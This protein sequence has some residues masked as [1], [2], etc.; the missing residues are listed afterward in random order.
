[1][2][3]NRRQFLA[4]GLV[5]G[6]MAIC[7][8]LELIS[9]ETGYK[10]GTGIAKITD[11]AIGQVMQGMSDPS[12]KITGVETDLY[13]R[14]FVIANSFDYM[15]SRPVIIVVTD[16]WAGS[17]LIKAE[18]I[19]RLISQYALNYENLVISVTHTHS[20]SGG[21]TG[22]AVY[23]Y[24]NGGF[25]PHTFEC[26]V[27]GIVNSIQLAFN[28]LNSGK[29]YIKT[30][31]IIDCGR[32]RSTGAYL[33]NPSD[34]RA[35]YS[36]DSEMTLLRF[37]HV[38][39]G[40][41]VNIGALSWYAIHQTDRGQSNTLINGDNK[42]YASYLFEQELDNNQ[43]SFVAAF[44]NSNC[45]DISG[46]V[47]YNEL[48]NGVDDKAHM[49]YHGNQQFV[50]ATELF[51]A[52][53]EELQGAIDFQHTRVDMSNVS[54]ED[55]PGKRTWPGALGL[56]FAAGSK[57]DSIPKIELIDGV[58][59]NSF[60]L[61]E[62]ITSDNISV[63]E[64]IART[65]V[66]ASLESTFNCSNPNNDDFTSGH[67]PKP[68]VLCSGLAN[69]PV[70]PN[71]LPLQLIR[72]G[73]FVLTAIPGEITTMAGRRLQETVL[74][75]LESSGVEH[76]ALATYS[77][78]YSQYITTKE[79]YDKQHYEGASTLFG[80]YTLMAYQQEF[81][82]L[83]TALINGGIDSGLDPS[84]QSAPTS[85][86]I[87]IRN[88]TTSSVTVEF[89]KQSDTVVGGFFDSL[90]VSLDGSYSIPAHCDYAYLIPED[91]DTVKMR[92]NK[93][94]SLIIQNI[95]ISKLVTIGTNQVSDYSV[96]S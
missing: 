25:D 21:V 84:P 36:D 41:E 35:Q 37:A 62:G 59:I 24:A 8:P 55:M 80:P 58:V 69:P 11:P 20:G 54:I 47:E 78:E 34:E 61:D 88:P 93:N 68:I 75:E 48:P 38:N 33:N 65:A 40:Q 10:V 49:Q 70:T 90:A 31:T 50:K 5:M 64:Q 14:A 18:V 7:K 56:S 96:P 72:I 26:T 27:T 3:M 22:S 83:A 4:T 63:T 44:A 29:I 71:V 15:L 92:I 28:N 81:K 2:K 67:Y 9:Q 91:S 32:Q 86:R 87:T 23:E 77:N 42:G 73:N 74:N 43:G 45:G 13:S 79:E 66:S 52:A 46:N 85:R 89:F 6:G 82:K 95:V 17:E 12:Q 57:E 16:S 51:Y 76:L 30:G 39:Q 19:S 1:M 53:T 94:K 60:N